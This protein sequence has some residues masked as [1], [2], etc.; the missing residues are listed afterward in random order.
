MRRFTLLLVA[1]TIV[2]P[3]AGQQRAKTTEIVTK[4]KAALVQVQPRAGEKTPSKT[5]VGVIVDAKGLVIAPYAGPQP[6]PKFEVVLSSGAKLPAKVV[7]V[8]ANLGLVFLAL[9]GAKALAHA[10]LADSDAV[11]SGDAALALSWGDGAA[12]TTASVVMVSAKRRRLANGDNRLQVDS[13]I[14][15]GLDPC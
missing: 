10:G 7:R 4:A 8:Q 3:T 13:S 5:T 12:S 9:D 1:L 11:D 2:P 6:E 14:G 15:P